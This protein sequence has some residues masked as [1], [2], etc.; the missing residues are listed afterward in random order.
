MLSYSVAGLVSA[1][2]VGYYILVYGIGAI[3]ML[4][5]VFAFQFKRRVSII[6]GNFLGQSS[7][8]AYFLLQGDTASAVVCALCALM[9]ALFSKKDE[10]RYAASPAVIALFIVAFSTF[11][12]LT[13]TTWSD[14][15]PLLAGVFAVIASSR[16]TEKRLRQFSVLWCFSWLLNSVFKLYPVALLNDLFCT[17]S[18]VVALIRY[19]ERKGEK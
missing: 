13:F 11:S 19:R 15:F 12:V 5:S 18:T 3:A 2:G 8:V 9:L 10:W 7:W 17:V 4:I 16:S 14:V 6:I 1:L